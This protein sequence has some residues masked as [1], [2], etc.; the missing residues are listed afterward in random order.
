MKGRSIGEID[1]VGFGVAKHP[2]RWRHRTR[3]P[4][5]NLEEAHSPLSGPPRLP[6]HGSTTALDDDSFAGHQRRSQSPRILTALMLSPTSIEGRG[7]RARIEPDR[8]QTAELLQVL[9][10]RA[11]VA[12]SRWEPT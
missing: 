4:E 6:G 12:Q 5:R 3:E 2:P 1:P 11:A 10:A 7:N 9:V 8:L